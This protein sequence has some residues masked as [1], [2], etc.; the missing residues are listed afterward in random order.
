MS[1]STRFP[2]AI[3][4][5]NIKAKTIVKSI[6]P[7]QGS[8]LMSGIFQ[9]VIYELVIHQYKS[10]AYHPENQRAIERFHQTLKNMLKT[11]SHQTGKD[12]D[13][14]VQLLLLAVRDSVQESLGFSPFELVFGHSV[15]CP[16]KRYKEKLLS[17]D[18][19]SL[20]I[21][22]YVSN[23]RHKLSEACE[24]AQNNLSSVQ[25]KMKERYDKYSQSGYFQPGDQVLALLPVRG[26]PLQARYFGPYITK[27]KF[28]DLNNIVSTPDRRK[29]TQLC[30]IFN[31]LK[32][33][34]NRD[35]NNVVQCANM[36]HLFH[37]IVM[38]PARLSG[39]VFDL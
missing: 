13:E 11:Y 32:S 25:S 23:F 31:M 9:Q 15:R 22:S 38:G 21:L 2:E 29:N 14:G 35:K 6:Q 18:D 4:L 12:W 7:D 24:L 20:N 17:E 39:K 19:S 34:V 36:F 8:N 3:P 26:K 1:T 10:S 33:S 16:L 27:E 30:H 5:R 28:G 37:K